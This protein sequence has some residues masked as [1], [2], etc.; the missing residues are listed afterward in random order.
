[1]AEL[2]SDPEGRVDIDQGREH[3]VAKHAASGSKLVVIQRPGWGA[4]R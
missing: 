4:R 3:S 2:I 1:M